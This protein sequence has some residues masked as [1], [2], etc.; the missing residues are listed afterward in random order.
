MMKSADVARA[1][2]LLRKL[3]DYRKH[4]RSILDAESIIARN[5][6]RP[7]VEAITPGTR[8]DASRSKAFEL[9]RNSVANYWDVEVRLC[10]LALEQLGI[11]APP[12]D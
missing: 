8:P 2:E 6:S 7:E 3:G 11:E 10:V 12:E 1:T 4:R 9:V 5:A